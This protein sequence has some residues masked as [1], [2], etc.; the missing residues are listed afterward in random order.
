MAKQTLDDIRAAERGIM[1]CLI[2]D[3]VAADVISQSINSGDFISEGFGN[4]Y[5][6]I[7]AYKAAGGPVSDVSA[8][9]RLLSQTG[10]LNAIG[11]VQEAY[12][13]TK[14]IPGSLTWYLKELRKA[15]ALRRLDALATGIRGHIDAGQEPEWLASYVDAQLAAIV[16]REDCYVSSIGESA[17]DALRRIE[18]SRE[19]GSDVGRSVGLPCVDGILGG[20][21]DN[22]M[23]VLAAR[24][25]IGK[26]ALAVQIGVSVAREYGHVMLVSLEMS[27]VDIALR[28]IAK[29]SR[30]PMGELRNAATMQDSEFERVS[31]AVDDLKAVNM[32]MLANR[33]VT[34]SKIRAAAK[35]QKATSGLELVVIDYIG[36]VKSTDFRKPRYEQISEI[37]SQI[38]DMAMELEVPV[39]VLCQLSRAAEKELP[40]LSHLRDSGAIEQDADVV[41]LLHRDDKGSRE[42]RLDIAKNRQGATGIVELLYEP[43]LTTFR[44]KSEREAREMDNYEPDFEEYSGGSPF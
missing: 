44:C 6:Q 35:L 38:K 10:V 19:R 24:P 42:A 4:A 21:F 9:T 7:I 31:L 22:D 14:A 39:L 12:E 23:A 28:L 26:T 25:S 43:A 15:K 27:R 8:I 17:E 1:G 32:S 30:V 3:P 41:M 20:L 33:N 11:G 29:Y 36:L 40:M 18:R 34:A 5:E 13:W 2:I 37:S 16:R